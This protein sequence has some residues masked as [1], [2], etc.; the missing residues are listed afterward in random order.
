MRE[1]LKEL[2]DISGIKNQNDVFISYILDTIIADI[3]IFCNIDE[4]PKELNDIVIKRAYGEVLRVTMI[5]LDDDGASID[6]NGIHSI[7]E[8]DTTITYDNSM[9]KSKVISDISNQYKSY[10][11]HLLYAYRKM[12]W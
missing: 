5:N 4:I 2:L 12:R 6:L 11:E 9:S 7:S 1:K 8:G 3:K 10:G